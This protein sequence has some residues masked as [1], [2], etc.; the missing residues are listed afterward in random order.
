[1]GRRGTGGRRRTVVVVLRMILAGKIYN[2]VHCF[3]HL[4]SVISCN[5]HNAIMRTDY[6]F[7][8]F[9]DNE[10]MEQRSQVICLG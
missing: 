5:P 10:S 2:D 9:T 4:A 6:C 7:Q 1:M 8:H 3:K